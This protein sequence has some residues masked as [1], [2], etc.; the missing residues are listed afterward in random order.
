MNDRILEIQKLYPRIY[1]A[2]H[3]EHVK[4]RSS[5]GQISSRDAGILAHLEQGHFQSPKTLAKHLN[6][7]ASTLSEALHNMVALG[8][9]SFKIDENDARQTKF[10]LTNDGA[11]A[12]SQNSVLDSNKVANMLARLSEE[13]QQKVIDGLKL[14]ANATY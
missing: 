13:D 12:I 11:K 7:A 14:F 9:V 8:F 2:C 4:K 10:S 5:K 1:M 6:I 3:V